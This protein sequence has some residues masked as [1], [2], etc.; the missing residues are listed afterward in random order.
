M[1][2]GISIPQLAARLA[3]KAGPAPDAGADADNKGGSPFADILNG[4]MDSA[5]AVS[6]AAFLPTLLGDRFKEAMPDAAAETVVPGAQP[7]LAD[8]LTALPALANA[9]E[10][11][12][13]RRAEPL[14]GQGPADGL[15]TAMQALARAPRGDGGLERMARATV[16][17]PL[18]TAEGGI[19]KAAEAKASPAILAANQDELEA[20]MVAQVVAEAKSAVATRLPATPDPATAAAAALQAAAAV[21]PAHAAMTQIGSINEFRIITPLG[22]DPWR[23]AIG[24]SL[25]IMTGQQ[26]HRAELVLTPPQLGRVEVSL[27]M[28][29]DQANAI[30]VS[31]NPAVREALENALPRLQELLADAGIVLNS[32]VGS[33]LPRN[34]TN[35]DPRDGANRRTSDQPPGRTFTVAATAERGGRGLVDVFA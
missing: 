6:A 21:A 4:Q 9:A 31:A 25:V 20:S 12:A 11:S 23:S 27:T 29:G 22:S 26:Q 34:A 13:L 19:G 30:F 5:G 16:P 10:G 35:G 24:D 7:A 15:A 32:Q 8:M 17:V 18:A 28:T 33:E 1:P 3:M 2:P 14:P